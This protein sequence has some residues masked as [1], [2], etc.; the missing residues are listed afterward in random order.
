MRILCRMRVFFLFFAGFINIF[1]GESLAADNPGHVVLVTWDGMR[2]DFVS[3]QYSPTLYSL[4]ERG[5]FFT[6]HHSV[7]LSAT[8]VN[9]TAISTGAYPAHDGIVGN[10]EFR[11]AIDPHKPIH[12]ETL[13]DVRKG[14]QLSHDQ[15]IRRP[16][17]AE[18][19]RGAGYKSAVAGAKP[20]ALLLDRFPR[21]SADLGANVFAG[22]TLPSNLLQIITDQYGPFPKE[23]SKG[24][25]RNDWT[26]SALLNPLWADGV[27]AFSHLWMNEP[28]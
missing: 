12:T 7:Y 2:P 21:K 26:T 19:V 6:H 10:S 8:E 20:I 9:G 27:P 16:T 28:D 23:T 15:Y 18:I 13:A 22:S 11:P 1:T 14:D 3:K 25:T 24:P 17:L 4:V 5:V